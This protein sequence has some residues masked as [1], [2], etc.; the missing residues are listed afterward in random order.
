MKRKIL[1]IVKGFLKLTRIEHSLMLILAVLIG[2][3]LSFNSIKEFNIKILP[4]ISSL[5]VPSFLSMSA[6]AINDYFDYESDRINKRFDRPLVSKIIKRDEAL[7]ISLTLFVISL[8]ISFFLNQIAFLIAF[9]LGFL[10]F[11]YSFR[12]KDIPLIGNAYIALCMSIPVI[13][14]GVVAENL[15]Q[16]HFFLFLIIFLAGLAR[17]ISHSIRDYK[18]DAIA[19]GSKNIVA[20]IGKKRSAQLSFL[21]YLIAI[22]LSI[23]VFFFYEPYKFNLIYAFF[24]GI[25]DILLFYVA[26]FT[27]NYNRTDFIKKTRNIT[28]TAMFL[29]LLGFFFPLL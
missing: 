19:R 21:L 11:L 28:L 14:G 27:F 25:C 23:L 12:L 8:Y 1:E 3:L 18:G 17:E 13:F 7:I 26:F 20:L 29:A 9:S 4:L 10:S 15:K 2:E 22:F 6:F 24:V 16:I 5:L